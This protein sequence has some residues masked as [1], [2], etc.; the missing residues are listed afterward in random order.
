MSDTKISP[1]SPHASLSDAD[2]AERRRRYMLKAVN[3]V[4]L[5]LAVLLIVYISIDTFLG[6]PYLTNHAY[7]TFQFWVCAVFMASFFLEM[8]YARDRW[9]YWRHRWLFFLLSIPY[10]NIISMAHV[11]PDPEALYFLR[12]IPLARGG[13]A[14]AIIVGYFTRN[15]VTGVFVTYTAILVLVVYFCSLIIFEREQPVNPQIPDFSSALWFA[16]MVVT[17]IGCD[18]APMTL[19]GKILQIV[20]ASMGMIMFPLFTVYITSTV[21][22]LRNRAA[23]KEVGQGA[24]QSESAN[25]QAKADTSTTA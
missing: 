18:I 10:L 4:V 22:R 6:I 23:Q 5:L 7:M 16:C 15:R 19:S 24:S 12:F 21:I 9:R 17:T 13:L 2:K 25:A 14:V 11:Q 1:Q 8:H 3:L 20:L